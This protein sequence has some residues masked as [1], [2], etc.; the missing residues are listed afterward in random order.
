MN[1]DAGPVAVPNFAT[2]IRPGTTTSDDEASQTLIFV[3]TPVDPSAFRTLPAI[4]PT[5]VLTYELATDVNSRFKDLTVQVVLQDSGPNGP[6]AQGGNDVNRSAVQTFSIVAQHINDAP[7]F[8]IP[9]TSITVLEDN[10]IETGLT[11]TTFAGFATGI[12]HGP[13]T[14]LD[15]PLNQDLQFNVISVTNS[16]LFATQPAISPS[17]NLTFVTAKDQNGQSV[18][19][20]Q[21]QDRERLNLADSLLSARRTFTIN[22]TSVNDAPEFDLP[23][24][25]LATEDQ[26]VV[27]VV[28]FATNLRPGTTTSTDENGQTF[29]VTVTAA[30]PTK[31]ALQPSIAADGTLQFRTAV[32]VNGSLPVTVFLTDDGPTATPGVPHVN[33]SIVKTFTINVAPI[34]DAPLFTIPVRQLTIDEDREEFLGI[35]Q[36]SFPNFVTNIL[37][38]PLTAVDEQQPNQLPTFLVSTNAP[39]LFSQQPSVDANGTLIFKTAPN[40]NG[41]ATVTIRLQDSGASSPAP[42][43]NISSE[44]TITLTI[45]PINDAPLFNI[46]ASITSNE[47]Q[48]VVSITGFAT[49][50]LRG[51]LG[52]DD[53]ST[54]EV[55]FVAVANDPNA[56]EIQP[57]ILADGTLSFKSALNVNKDTRTTPT[58][59]MDFGVQVYLVDNGVASPLPHN[60]RSITKSFSVNV[61]PVNDSPIPDSF[62]IP[63]VEDTSIDIQASDVLVGDLP[64]P[65]DEAGQSLFISQ[66]QRTSDRGG[67]IVPVFSGSQIVSFR[68]TPPLNM[69]NADIFRYVVTDNGSPARSAT[70]TITVN[71]AGV[72]DRPQFTVGAPQVFTFE[73]SGLVTTP[74]A[75]NILAGPPAA[76]DEISGPN[77]QTVS[78]ELIPDRPELFSQGPSIDANGVLSFTPAPNANGQAII[79]VTAVDSGSGV[80]PNNNRSSTAFL[81]VSIA[82]VNDAPVFTAGGNVSANEDGGPQ[83]IAWA[84]G[85]APAA[86]ILGSPVTANDEASQ[87][88][89][90]IV[91]PSSPSLFSVQ[92]TISRTGQLQFTPAPNAFGVTTVTV[93][94]RDSGAGDG[95]NQNTSATRTFTLTINPT[96]DA[97]FG[98]SDSYATNEDTLLTISAPGILANDSDI[99]LPADTLSAV[100]VSATSTLGAAVIV[101]ADGSISYDPRGVNA[102]QQLVGGQSVIDQFTY[103]VRDA[104]GAESEVVT[105]S[106]AVSG[107]NDAPVAVNDSF[108]IGVNQATLLAVLSNDTDVDSP[109]DARTIEIGNLPINGTVRVLQTGRIEY[110]PRTGFR[111]A[112]SFSYRVRDS[113]V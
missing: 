79:A 15:E 56:F 67:V 111:G 109:I 87:T 25:Q 64:G 106:V 101:N 5:G 11:P 98:N 108:P 107:I 28:N 46:P 35:P 14:A 66:V 51:P 29:T 65:A 32:D 58:T 37:M 88:V 71:V 80:A 1:E 74:W 95:L 72:N 92:P 82:A 55:T 43:S 73:D 27:R 86:G 10:E 54:Q 105:V 62:V 102:I 77:A 76:L 81:T 38:G 91:T 6:V 85:I 19:V 83:V 89:D 33:R 84:T 52:A 20:V 22:V 63:G 104:A 23:T 8:A 3:V 45:N 50:V 9:V 61:L 99:D 53:E 18:V 57:T 26:G 96:N 24:T 34:N 59:L 41:R 13:T 2:N 110:T 30:D 36:S 113:L 44:L 78:F 47:D 48:G 16:T 68:Y 90:F 17:G 100:R 75:S 49:N 103:R 93:V 69:A 12:V 7:D 70:G 94:A 4:S 97:P 112:D 60:N 39:E 21:L 31:F 40:K 42:N